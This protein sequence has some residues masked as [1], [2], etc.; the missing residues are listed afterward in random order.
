[1]APGKAIRIL[2]VEDHP[3]FREGLAMIISSQ[4]DMVPVA[5]ATNA[6][7]AIEQFHIHRPDVTLMDLKLP[8]RNGTDALI[9]I[10]G[11]FPRARII[12]L[13]TSRLERLPMC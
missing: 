3:I 4:Q 9:A 11:D 10:R 12:M 13:T 2:I 5:Q 1:M 8:G 6:G 7:E